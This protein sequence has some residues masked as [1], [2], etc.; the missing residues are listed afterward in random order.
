MRI[1]LTCT[2][3]EPS[4]TQGKIDGIGMYTK[5]LLDQFS[6]L[7]LDVTPYSFPNNKNKQSGIKNGKVF[8]LSFTSATLSS[9][10]KPIA[11]TIYKNIPKQIDL[12]HVTDHMIP[13][14]DRISMI[15]TIHDAL[16][17][18]H[19]EWYSSKLRGIKNWLRKETMKW[20]KHFITISQAMVPELVRYLDIPES[21]ITVVHN[22]LPDWWHEK[23]SPTEIK[24]T[25]QR[26]GLPK[27]FILFTG[28][29]Q[30]KKNVA[31]LIEAF[32]Q[33]PQDIQQ[34]YPLVIAGKAGWD[35]TEDIIAIN[36][37]IQHKTGYWLNY[38]SK[39]DIRTLY[40]A[41]TLYVFPSLHEGFGLTLLEAFASGTPV[42]T[43]SVPALQE[44]GA[45]AVYFIDPLSIDSM[46]LGMRN[47]L[48][49][50]GLRQQYINSGSLRVRDFTVDRCI[51]G[52]LN[53]YEKFI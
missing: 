28:T 42:M 31:R 22:G 52:T 43:S 26:L 13:R 1:G 38:V 14:V 32:L 44:I 19:P 18:K 16:M 47:F 24:N 25:L 41:A 12:L 3:I 48:T 39:E 21:K 11:D 50:E 29:I 6:N 2:T 46:T 34:E 23:V 4:L 30:P 45:N 10:I 33:L 37:L 27:K 40:Q 15:A 5:T 20:P 35:T 17:F 8:P 9:F 36:K 49:S 53:V 7:N 51:R